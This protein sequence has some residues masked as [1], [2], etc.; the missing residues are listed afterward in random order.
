MVWV[1]HEGFCLFYG[2]L[3]GSR[4]ASVIHR[5]SGSGAYAYG[6]LMCI[7]LFV[8]SFSFSYGKPNSAGN[9]IEDN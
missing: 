1:E 7:I 3:W 5:V 2:S 6:A 4:S 8:S 9:R